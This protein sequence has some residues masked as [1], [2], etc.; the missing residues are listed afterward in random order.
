MF[1]SRR[2]TTGGSVCKSSCYGVNFVG[3]TEQKR[4][5]DAED[6]R[7]IRD[8]FVLQNVHAAVFNILVGHLGNRGGGGDAADEKQRG[9]DHAGFDGDGEVGEDSERE[10]HQPDADVGFRELEQLRNLAPL[11]HVVGDHHQNSGEH[12]QRHVSSPAA[13]Q[14]AGCTAA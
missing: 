4:P 11:A 14:I 13:P 7:V 5:V 12:R 1:R 10:G 6:R 3:G 9:K 2:I 8:V